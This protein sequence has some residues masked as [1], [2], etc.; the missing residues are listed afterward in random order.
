[1]KR[2]KGQMA[3]AIDVDDDVHGDP[4]NF[5]EGEESPLPD[6]PVTRETKKTKNEVLLELGSGTWN[7]KK[8]QDFG[9]SSRIC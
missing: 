5:M 9:S 6:S 8:T 2:K 3:T 7:H 1:M 4:D